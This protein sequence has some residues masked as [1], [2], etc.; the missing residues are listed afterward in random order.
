MV[1]SPK[2]FLPNKCRLRTYPQ[3]A[4]SKEYAIAD[5][6]VLREVPA[7][8]DSSEFLPF[9][10]DTPRQFD[11]L[12]LN[13]L[14][15]ILNADIK[16]RQ[17]RRHAGAGMLHPNYEVLVKKTLELADLLYFQPVPAP[18]TAGARFAMG[19]RMD[20]N[21]A[22]DSEM[23]IKGAEYWRTMIDHGKPTLPSTG[24]LR[25]SNSHVYYFSLR[26]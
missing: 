18:G 10:F 21:G 15:V 4:R 19:S 26:C 6:G 14:L 13:P 16:F 1:L 9:A 17:Y 2:F 25:F 8:N 5:D 3:E 20:V 22:T 24:S 7:Q 12:G 11:E 23:G